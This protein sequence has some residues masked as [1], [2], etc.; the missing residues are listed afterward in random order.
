MTI[1]LKTKSCVAKQNTIGLLGGTF[2]PVHYGHLNLARALKRKLGFSELRLVPCA[3]PVHRDSPEANP[4]QRLEMLMRALHEFPELQVDNSEICRGGKS[5]SFDTLSA[6]R[7]AHPDAMLSMIM[8]C[9]AFRSFT[10]WY[11]WEVILDLCN[12]VAVN[13]SGF[14]LPANEEEYYRLQNRYIGVA[15]FGTC[16]QGDI[17]FI[18]MEEWP[19][20]STDIRQRLAAREPITGL[21][22]PEVIHYINQE[23]LYANNN[24]KG[25]K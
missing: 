25:M 12:I 14:E 10:K 13:R 3:N 20:S 23:G 1:F 8:G 11:Q 21:T 24:S 9:D 5:Y 19:V 22:P 6:L 18:T 17:L 16:K 2:D 7:Q 4:G 15:E